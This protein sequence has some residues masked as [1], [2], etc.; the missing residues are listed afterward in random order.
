MPSGRLWAVNAS[1]ATA[2]SGMV[3]VRRP[4]DAEGPGGEL[5]VLLGRLQLMGGDGPGLVDHLFG[6]Q[7]HRGAADRQ[8]TRPVGV[9]AVRRDGRV[10]VEDLHVVGADAQLVGH[11]HRP[12][13]LVALPVGGGAG[14]HLDLAGRQDPDRG[15]LPPPGGVV[16]R[17]Q[18]PAGGQAAHLHVRGQ[19]D[20][21][22]L[23]APR[24]PAP[25]LLGP[26]IVVAD[27]LERFGQ[28]RLVVAAVVDQAAD[29]VVRELV[30][31]RRSCAGG[32]RP[33]RRRPPWP[34]RR[35]NARWRR[36]P[37][38]GPAPR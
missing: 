35:W 36:S 23:A 8:R 15:R 26:Q 11:D 6:G 29:R 3:A 25:A 37:R 38:A 10:G 20:A 1:K 12:R 34:G 2:A 27:Q 16:E 18:G 14:D 30:G 19:A 4:L 9:H 21:Q 13:R 7:P 32:S 17:G 33:G 5:D 22:V 31:R 28:C 24:V